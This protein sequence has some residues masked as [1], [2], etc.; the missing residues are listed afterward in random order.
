MGRRNIIKK[1]T[2]TQGTSI[3][4]GLLFFMIAS[5]L[6]IVMLDGAVTAIKNVESD[7][8]TEQN[9]LTCSSAAKTL[10]DAVMD[11]CITKV[12]T[13]TVSGNTENKADPVWSAS[14]KSTVMQEDDFANLY[15]KKWLTTMDLNPA[16]PTEYDITIQGPGDTD[17]VAVKVTI[18]ANA[19]T[20]GEQYYDLMAVL[21]TG[22]KNDSCQVTLTLSGGVNT[23]TTS[24]QQQNNKKVTTTTAKYT[25]DAPDI[26]YGTKARTGEES[27]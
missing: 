11:I 24:T 8:R 2:S 13:V 7:R 25:W 18:T 20:S 27:K 9:F 4:F 14:R 12:Q 22:K 16:G 5:V 6:S 3:F 23:E 1:V 10:R 19:N 26:I 15:L 17:P 21:S